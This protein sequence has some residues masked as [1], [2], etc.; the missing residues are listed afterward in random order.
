MKQKVS[1]GSV[2]VVLLGA[3]LLFACGS[4]G[5]PSAA[6]SDST[7]TGMVLG[8]PF[9]GADVLLV[10]PEQWKSA[11]AGSS[12]ILISDTPNL[13]AQITSGQTTAPGRLVIVRL[14]QRDANA[15]IT[16]LTSGT[17]T[18]T[19]EG[20]PSSRYGDVSVSG[21]DAQCGFSKDFTDQVSI[22]VTAA[23]ADGTSATVDLN[24]HFSQGGSLMG[25]VTASVPCD[26]TAVDDYLNRN[27]KCG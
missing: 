8:A 15:A 3:A 14:E 11:G 2:S 27:P 5:T 19:G 7:L 20:T 24:A 4:G 26:Q 23:G 10:H 18:T 21:V 6:P 22:E 1:P 16:A 13:C 25:G 12:A 9:S 17:F